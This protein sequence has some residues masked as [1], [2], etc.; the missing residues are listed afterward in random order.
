MKKTEHTL[1][2]VQIC[3][4]TR[5]VSVNRN[6]SMANF[7]AREYKNMARL[8]LAITAAW[9]CM[10]ASPAKV[11]AA[12]GQPSQTG[13]A[14]TQEKQET[15]EMQ[16]ARPVIE[17]TAVLSCTTDGANVN[18]TAAVS[19]P[20]PDPAVFDS[21]WYL[22]EMQPH[23]DELKDRT[24]YAARWSRGDTVSYALPLNFGT[25]SD[26]LYSKFVLAVFDGARYYAIS[27]P[28]YITNPEVVARNKAPLKQPI[29]KKGL[30]LDGNLLS[31][32][33]ELGVKHT[34]INI[35]FHQI[36]GEGIDYEYDGKTYHFNKAVIEGYDKIV[37]TMR[38]K[39]IMVTAIILN[40]WNENTPQLFLPGVKKT[41]KANYYNFNASTPEGVETIKAIASFLAK[42][43]SGAE[44]SVGK[45]SNWVIGNEINNN[46]V[47]NYAGERE[48]SDYVREYMKAFRVFYTAVKSV[49]SNDRL[50]FSTDF[51]WNEPEPSLVKY[52]A[53]DVIDTFGAM[54]RAGGDISWGLSYH[55]Y[56]DP[57]TEPEFWD[58]DETGRATESPDTIIVN[59]NNLHILT[60]HMNRPELL[61]PD[62]S[63]RSIIL[64]EQGFTSQSATRG[65]VEKL[66][67]AALAY[68]YYLADSN[69]DID[70]IIMNRQVDNVYETK[71]SVALGL[72]KCDMSS[73]DV[74]K[75]TGRKLSWAIFRTIDWKS[76]LK[77]TQFAKE[78]I[79]IEK[80]SDVIPNF[81]WKKYE[82]QEN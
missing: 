61:A 42:R 19:G 32:A 53:R 14:A 62:T 74:I 10:M 5:P 24:D 67:A 82:N 44:G 73:P 27:E 39:D 59:F 2:S 33:L 20:V 77:D 15:Q 50:Y 30:L 31:D 52:G 70:A 40:G 9:A 34:S 16:E 4:K 68:A 35:A 48:L 58:D 57:L 36:L 13:A 38:T 23:E 64:S 71:T 22:F 78:L 60:D 43:Y 1:T 72:W 45:I 46:E 37:D 11:C 41:A 21:A 75:H 51:F 76:S 28:S 55:P 54:V 49:N 3:P 17:E 18:I 12:T 29:T 81:K 65:D 80:W 63:V 56:P 26:R 69:P 6:E 25:A 7:T 79:G 8:L 47:W 66:Q